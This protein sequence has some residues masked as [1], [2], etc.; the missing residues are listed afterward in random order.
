MILRIDEAL[1]LTFEKIDSLPTKCVFLFPHRY[2]FLMPCQIIP[3]SYFDM[4]METRKNAQTRV[5]HIWH[6]C[7]NDVDP[8]ICPKRALIRLARI[9]GRDYPKT[10][11]LFLQM[12]KYGV[13]IGKAIV[14][15]HHL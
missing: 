15:L 6:L 12:N 13:V 4:T 14:C 10:G 11:P 1:S 2:P 7:A 9:Y 5:P 8:R 3:G